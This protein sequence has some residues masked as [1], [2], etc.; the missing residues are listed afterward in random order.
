M[1]GDPKECRE[2]A[3]CCREMA[4]CADSAV[5]RETFANLAD[6]WERLAIELETAQSFVQAM[7]AIEPQR[8]FDK[9]TIREPKSL[10]VQVVDDEIIVTRPGSFYSVTYYKP[11]RSPQ[12][13]ARRMAD[14]D[15]LRISMTLSDFLSQAWKLANDKAKALGWII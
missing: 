9:S 12:L 4:A 10:R 15:D 5:E 7:D 8:P 1:P 14:R 6:T 11:D 2:N 13:I 3:V